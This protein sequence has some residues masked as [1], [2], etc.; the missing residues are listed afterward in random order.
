MENKFDIEDFVNKHYQLF[1][2]EEP[3]E[4]HFDRFKAKLEQNSKKKN[5]KIFKIS[6]R[7]T[8][9]A[10]VLILGFI[11]FNHTNDF[12][13][14]K[15]VSETI[16]F[17][18]NENFNEVSA[19]YQSQIDSKINEINHLE[20]KKGVNQK[21]QI[22]EDLNEL[23]NSFN[24]LNNEYKNNP[25]NSMIQNAMITNYQTRV[26]MLDMIADKLKKFC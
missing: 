9:V 4:G 1:N 26:S 20:C 24:E 15:K 3:D 6:M 22:K 19:Y 8:S 17:E 2:Q 5:N 25:D 7:I 14:S 18:T 21:E 12:L 23:T 10:A 13:K 11:I 16:S